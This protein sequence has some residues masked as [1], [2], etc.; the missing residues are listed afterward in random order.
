MILRFADINDV[1]ILAKQR[2]EMF[3]AM[4]MIDSIEK[5]EQLITASAK[6]FADE[7]N[8]RK[9]HAVLAEDDG[10]IVAGGVLSIQQRGPTPHNS[11]GFEGYIFNMYTDSEFRGRPSSASHQRPDGSRS[12]SVCR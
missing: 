2:T 5:Y 4:G 1:S 7:F 8:A 6:Y 10:R 9:M 12:R 3:K 11:S